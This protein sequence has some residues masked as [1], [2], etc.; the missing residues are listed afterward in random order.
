A[1]G[2]RRGDLFWHLFGHGVWQIMLVIAVAMSISTWLGARTLMVT[3]AAVQAAIVLTIPPGVAA[4]GFSRCGDALIG[5][6]VALVFAT[7]AP[8]G[9]VEKPRL[10]AAKV[11]HESAWS[12]RSMVAALEQRDVDA[13]DDVLER[14]RRTEAQMAA[15][16]TAV[17]EGVAVVR[18]SPFLRRH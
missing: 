11:L 9:P 1:V 7:V 10:Q 16:N 3:Q 14:T 8:V 15:L 5:C 12:I 17:T 13:A 18:V 4:G 2:V 6:L